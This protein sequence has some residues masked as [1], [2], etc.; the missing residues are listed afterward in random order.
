[1]KSKI[2]CH[3]NLKLVLKPFLIGGQVW[4]SRQDPCWD[5]G[6]KPPAIMKIVGRTPC[7]SIVI[8]WSRVDILSSLTEIS[9]FSVAVI[10]TI[11]SW[12]KRLKKV[13][14]MSEESYTQVWDYSYDGT[15]KVLKQHKWTHSSLFRKGA[16]G[17]VRSCLGL[18][19]WRTD[20]TSSRK[21]E[22]LLQRTIHCRSLHQCTIRMREENVQHF[23]NKTYSSQPTTSE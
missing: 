20:A 16:K 2:E 9:T 23:V 4:V 12:L 17:R 10:R 22:G 6:N 8:S 18:L 5:S 15:E 14:R 11:Y 21:T 7:V 13:E 1:M 19:V 3:L